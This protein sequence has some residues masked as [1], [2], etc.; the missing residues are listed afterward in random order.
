MPSPPINGS[1]QSI[2]CAPVF[3]IFALQIQWRATVRQLQP[4]SRRRAGLQR[5]EVCLLEIDRIVPALEQN[6]S[7]ILCS[8]CR[9]DFL[10]RDRNDQNILAASPKHFLRDRSGKAIP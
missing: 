9:S 5:N 3:T 4:R 7:E 1:N 2:Q 10:T 6:R 8:H